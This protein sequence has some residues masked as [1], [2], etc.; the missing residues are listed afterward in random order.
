LPLIPINFLILKNIKKGEVK[1]KKKAWLKTLLF[2]LLAFTIV[3]GCSSQTTEPAS[4]NEKG[5]NQTDSSQSATNKS[6]G[7][8]KFGGT[9]VVGTVGDPDTLNPLVSNTVSGN[10]VHSLMYPKLLTMSPDGKKV[11]YLAESIETS[12]DGL[13][14]TIKLKDGITWQDGTPLT[15]ADVKFTG[16]IL[17]EH[18]LQWTAGIFNEVESVET[19]DDLTVVYNLKK[20][21]PPFAGT[22]GYWVRIV[23]KH[24][25]E[26]VD[27]P[28]NFTN[29]NP[30]GAGPFEL[31]KWEKGQYIEFKSVENW[32]ASPEG[33][34]YVEKVILKNYPDVNTMV[35][36]LQRGDVHVTASDVPASAAKQLEAM[37]GMKVVETPS[38]GYFYYD[39]NLDETKGPSPML[40][41]NFRVAM[42]TATDRQTMINIALEGLAIPIDTPVS[43]VLK[44]WIN[45]NAKAP[46][47]N[48]EEAKN[49]LAQAGYSDTNG[50]GILNS[51]AKFGGENVELE[52]LYDSSSIYHQKVSKILEQNAKEIGVKLNPKPVEKNTMITLWN[53][54][55][56]DM[57]I[58]G[59]GTL[60][61]PADYLWILF[62][63]GNALNRG[64]INS[65]ELDAIV[66]A[67]RHA[68]TKEE[69]KAKV[70]EA[71]EWFAEEFPVVP[72]YVQTFKLAYN[73]NLFEGFEL[74]PSNLQGL[75][76]PN[77]LSKVYEKQ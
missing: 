61:E 50:D 3:V 77:S 63:S 14:I 40:D 42:A 73:S 20:P 64:K 10:W 33:K 16:E 39:F 70:F 47:Y 65:P 38:L 2:V 75:V 26:K 37:N 11:P 43:P 51:P 62:H 8:D 67:A 49:M 53:E 13:Q 24:I 60:E 59:W 35:L 7:E 25:W 31:V 28:K 30:I 15:S 57:H 45:P 9:L 58:G 1:M 22:F 72:L 5:S 56:F 54:G 55:N 32:F 44:E 52:V 4:S 17:Y 48:P 69:A 19:P 36:A 66:T 71:Q 74:Y 21:Y 34:P 68:V 46:K 12:E 27:D 29:D 41:K 18:K 23:P 6:K 76:D